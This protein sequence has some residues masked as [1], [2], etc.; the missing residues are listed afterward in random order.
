MD[1]FV[2]FKPEAELIGRIVVGYTQIE[3]TMM[4]C[5][6]LPNND[7]FDHVFKSV[8]GERFS[9]NRINTVSNMAKDTYDK[10]GILDVFLEALSRVDECREIRNSYAHANWWN[11]GSG[12]LAFLSLDP[13][14]K[15]KDHLPGLG[16]EE[17]R[18]V[19]LDLLTRQM[20]FFQ[21]TESLLNWLNVEARHQ[22]NLHKENGPKPAMR[23]TTTEL[24]AL[25]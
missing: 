19:D 25:R 3:I 9:K 12:R 2:S 15:R 7:N 10:F 11:D 23:L 5:A 6:L 20:E 8:Y 16:S 1:S 4:N 17:R 18:Y 13:L 22:S 14:A 24:R 21:D